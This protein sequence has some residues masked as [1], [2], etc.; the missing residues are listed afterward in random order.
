M[1]CTSASSSH[2][3]KV[4]EANEDACIALPKSGVWAVADGMGG[5]RDGAF[6]SH[7]IVETLSQ[8]ER[9][10]ALSGLV[11]DVEKRLCDVHEQLLQRANEQTVVGSTVAVLMI[12]QRHSV[13]LWAGD[14]RIY[15]LREDKL[16]RL[17]QDHSYVEELVEDGRLS[18]EDADQHP[19]AN[20]I[21]R[22][23]GAGE[24]LYLD[25]RLDKVSP[26]DIYLICSDGLYKELREEEIAQEMKST[27]PREICEK[28]MNRVLER[29][30]HDN[31]SIVSVRLEESR[32]DDAS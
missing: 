2:A 32:S 19:D 15:R 13:C 21:T 11:D 18:R 4:R 5:H 22:A 29:D 25:A 3:G 12:M 31:V 7:L 9:K 28:L 16:E 26:S 10:S 23:I 1:I 30:A 24:A 20:V 27:E 8:V 17:T 6:A 14:T